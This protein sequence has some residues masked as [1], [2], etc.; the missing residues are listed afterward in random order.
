MLCTATNK[1]AKRVL[2]KSKSR[3]HKK[4]Q[5][6]LEEGPI[7]WTFL[8]TYLGVSVLGISSRYLMKST[9]LQLSQAGEN[10]LFAKVSGNLFRLQSS[11][12]SAHTRRDSVLFKKSITEQRI[13]FYG[14]DALNNLIYLNSRRARDAPI[15]VSGDETVTR[16]YTQRATDIR[17]RTSKKNESGILNYNICGTNVGYTTRSEN[18]PRGNGYTFANQAYPGQAYNVGSLFKERDIGILLQLLF[19]CGSYF[20]YQNIQLIADSKFGH[21]V[22]LAYLRTQKVY[23]ACSFLPS[24][25]GHNIQELS[26]KKLSVEE[27]KPFVAKLLARKHEY[28]AKSDSDEK[29]ESI[30]TESDSGNQRNHDLRKTERKFNKLKTPLQFFQKGLTYTNKGTYKVWGTNINVFSSFTVKLYIHAIN[31]SKPV[32][33]LSNF[34]AAN[35]ASELMITVREKDTGKKVKKEVSTSSAHHVFRK[36][37][38]FN[39]QSDAKRSLLKLSSKHYRRW[40]QKLL[41]KT[42][43]DAIIN[44][45]LNSLLDPSCEIEP[46]PRQ[47]FNLITELLEA[48]ANMRT[49]RK[50]RMRP[51]RRHHRS[52]SS[53][54]PR[55]GSDEMLEVG[56]NCSGGSHIGSVRKLLLLQRTKQCAFCGRSKAAFKC[57]SC[58]MHLCFQIPSDIAGIKFR[59]NGPCCFQRFHGLSKFPR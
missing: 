20:R 36:K 24:R 11:N 57:R 51:F 12:F 1:R 56:A 28:E 39:D 52:M 40:P 26:S 37:M 30:S 35:P 31:D 2:S 16:M 10:R 19:S 41:A 32:F 59:S 53:K 3:E 8:G 23:S 17:M 29:T 48:G 33:R 49:R 44:A 27:K 46:W 54:R 9:P 14:N 15:Q 13:R 58:K 6:D 50:K 43:E 5:R 55:P 42:L 22:P 21:I 34:H 38:G 18:D 25:V 45:Y 4:R 7:F 47:V